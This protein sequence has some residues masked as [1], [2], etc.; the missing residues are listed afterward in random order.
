MKAA[1][2]YNVRCLVLD[3]VWGG[4]PWCWAVH[5]VL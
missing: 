2:E 4:W 5:V 3:D 1:L